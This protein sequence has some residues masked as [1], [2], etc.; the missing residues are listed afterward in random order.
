MSVGSG[1]ILAIESSCDETAAAVLDVVERRILSSVVFS[2]VKL[3]EIYGG[4]VPEIA[5][6]SHMEKIDIVVAEALRDAGISD[7][8]EVEIVAATNKP[9]LAGSLL[10]GFSFAKALAWSVGAKLI[11]V[12]HL[13][14]H[15]SSARIAADMSLSSGQLFPQ[16]CLLASGGNTAIYFVKDDLNFV[17]LGDTLDDAAGEAFDKVAKLLGLG[18]PGGA[19]IEALA[20]RVGFTDFLRLP[21]TERL[22][23]KAK[24]SFSGIKTAILYH[25]V[26]VGFLDQS[27]SKSS[28]FKVSD[29]F[30][31]EIAS[32]LLVAVG[33]IFVASLESA[34]KLAPEP[35]SSISFVGG[36][37][38]NKYLRR[39][40]KGFA[41]R[42]GLEFV[43]PDCKF[44]VDNAAMI[45]VA[46][47]SMAVLGIYSDFSA[48]ILD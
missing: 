48:D 45:A 3:H 15:I 9:G 1:K 37:A 4:V 42:F 25:L 8:R 36:V 26:S 34:I 44:C 43:A 28:D 11:A 29:E 6:R 12:D 31:A 18:Y 19:K 7:L 24:F 16:L 35:V 10:V 39:R 33:D 30:L 14:G 40:L 22:T 46:A 41:E 13:F 47:Y 5:S 17:K 27:F 23:S 2:Q 21:R 20:K 32:S 38:C